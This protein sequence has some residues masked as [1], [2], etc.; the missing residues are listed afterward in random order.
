M[1]TVVIGPPGSG[2]NHYVDEH[3]QPG[4]IV[5]DYDAIAVALGSPDSHNHPEHI[6]VVTA[7]VRR[8]AIT[9]ALMRHRDGFRVWL[10]QTSLTPVTMDRYMREGA[11]IIVIDTPLVEC[12]NRVTKLG[13]PD[14]FHEVIDVWEP[15]TDPIEHHPQ[16]RSRD[17]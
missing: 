12:H 13:R 15:V 9:A 8:H 6:R 11:E 1:L 3:K 2:K 17:W 5:I 4:D 7:H 16:L 10:I 14:A